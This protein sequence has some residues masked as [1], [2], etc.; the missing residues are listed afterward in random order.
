[1]VDIKYYILEVAYYMLDIMCWGSQLG[2]YL[3]DIR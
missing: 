1:M 2:H 3:L